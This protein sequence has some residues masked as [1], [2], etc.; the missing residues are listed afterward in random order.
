MAL[1]IE[2]LSVWGTEALGLSSIS[3]KLAQRTRQ[4]LSNQRRNRDLT[5]SARDEIDVKALERV[6]N[7]AP[8]VQQVKVVQEIQKNSTPPIYKNLEDGKFYAVSDDT[9]VIDP[10]LL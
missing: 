10:D 4:G 2:N 8:L 5:Q 7:L 6:G 3:G 9:L 1:I